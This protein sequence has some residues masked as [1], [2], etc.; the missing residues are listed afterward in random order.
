MAKTPVEL[1]IMEFKHQKREVATFLMTFNQP[2]DMEGQVVGLPRG[3]KITMRMK[4]LNDG[5]S[6][7]LHWMTEK[8]LALNGSVIFE[9]TTSGK[10][11]KTVTFQDAYCVNY[12]ESWEDNVKDGVLA[13]WEE[14]TI[15]CRKITIGGDVHFSNTWE[16]VQ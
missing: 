15:S 2:T 13:H 9:D 12:I 16:L 4:A 1:R 7:L 5:S 6:D 8:K 10:V 14:I 3:G 11:M